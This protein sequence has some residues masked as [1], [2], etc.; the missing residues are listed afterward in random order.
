MFKILTIF[1]N[2][3][4]LVLILKYGLGELILNLVTKITLCVETHELIIE[5]LNS[6]L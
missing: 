3:K 2:I 5:L 6:K 1:F 4:N